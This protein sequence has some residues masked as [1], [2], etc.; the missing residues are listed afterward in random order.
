MK[1]KYIY[2]LAALLMVTCNN[3]VV[4]PDD[5]DEPSASELVSTQ[6]ISAGGNVGTYSF[7]ITSDDA[8]TI[9]TNQS[10]CTVSPS[11]GTSDMTITVDL[12]QN[13]S[14]QPRTATITVRV[15]NVKVTITITQS[16]VTET[17]TIG[18]MVY[19]AGGTFTMGCTGEQGSDCDNC[20]KPAHSV[21]LSSFYIGKYE[22]T[23]KEWLDVMGK[24]VSQI[25]SEYGW[26][27]YGVGDNYP[28]YYVSW[29]DIVG[30]SGS[31]Q[32]INGI[33]YYSNG[34]IY[35]LNQK[36]GKKYRLP[37]EAEWEYA[38]RGGASSKGY[39]YSGSNNVD[40]VAWYWGNSE[41]IYRCSPVG[42]KQANELGIYDM[43]GNV[44]EWCA[45][46]WGYYSSAAQTNPTGPTTGSNRVV[47]GG[48]WSGDAGSVRVSYRYFIKYPDYRY[49]YIG[50]RVA[51]SP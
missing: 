34:F 32:V 17:A 51:C 23:Q 19:V 41:S 15:G 8:W 13:T 39:K 24:N 43:S 6:S 25:A 36:T 10:W 40:A 16:G 2:I 46:W 7:D 28:M 1:K 33:T 49:Y 9:T 21:T 18:G 38:A 50:F 14:S 31:T 3:P 11:S 29:N 27:T 26:K 30:T 47:R 44:W 5:D 12:A 48:G 4:V 42:T 45:D 37:T 22:V 20:E 35:K